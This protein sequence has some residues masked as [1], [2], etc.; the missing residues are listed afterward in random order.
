MARETYQQSSKKI[1]GKST[2]T[3]GKTRGKGFFIRIILI[4]E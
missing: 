1:E 4:H 2:F 3:C